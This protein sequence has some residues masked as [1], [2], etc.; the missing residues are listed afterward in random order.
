M[1]ADGSWSQ[2]AAVH[3]VSIF[4]Y[5]V[6]QRLQLFRGTIIQVKWLLQ[7]TPLLLVWIGKVEVVQPYP[8]AIGSSVLSGFVKFQEHVLLVSS[9]L[10][11]KVKVTLVPTVHL[12]TA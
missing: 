9:G 8:E 3:W 6:L 10:S 4:S 7:S 5:T 12:P 1:F 11:V 2:F